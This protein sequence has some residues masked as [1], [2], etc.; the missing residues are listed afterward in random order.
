MGRLG[1]VE[2]LR[3]I[4]MS[5]VIQGGGGK[6][7]VLIRQSH[8]PHCSFG[9]TK[10]GGIWPHTS[11]SFTSQLLWLHVTHPRPAGLSA[12]EKT[13]DTSLGG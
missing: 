11:Q 7:H 1:A 3:R 4:A 9:K 13:S 6:I 8:S 12:D 5:V 10:E 2:E